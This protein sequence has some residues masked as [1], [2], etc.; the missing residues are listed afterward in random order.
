[1]W[2]TRRPLRA[3]IVLDGVHPTSYPQL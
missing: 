3:R 1:M 2:R